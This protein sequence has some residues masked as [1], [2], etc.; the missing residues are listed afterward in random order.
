[1]FTHL[2]TMKFKATSAAELAR[3][4]GGEMIPCSVTGRDSLPAAQEA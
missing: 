1:M 4:G 3:V 2:V